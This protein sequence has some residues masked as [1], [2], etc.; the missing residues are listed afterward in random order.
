LYISE[1][2]FHDIHQNRYAKTA[3]LSGMETSHGSN[4][5]R[6]KGLNDSTITQADHI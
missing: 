1:F 4:M 2:L 6:L 3:I 5:S